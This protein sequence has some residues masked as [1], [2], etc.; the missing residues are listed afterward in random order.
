MTPENVRTAADARKIVEERKLDHIKVGVFDNDGVMRGKYMGRDKF[1]SALDK[2][3]GFCDVVLG[4]DSNDQLYD[5]V[6]YTGWHTAYPDAP[7]RVLPDTCRNVPFEGD[8]VMF[9]GEFAEKAEAVCP[10][11]T[12][13]RVLKKAD[14]LGYKVNAATEFEFFMFKETPESIRAKGFRDLTT[15]TPGFFGYSVLRSSVHSEFYHQ[16]MNMCTGLRIPLEGL[17]TETGPGVLEAAIQYC[18]ALEAADR[19]ALFKTYTKVLAQRNGMMATFMAKWSKDWPGQ[20]G[21]IHTSLIRKSDGKAAFHD[22]SKPHNMSDEMRWFVGGQQKLMPELLAMVACTVNSYSRLIPGFWAPTTATWGVE[23]RTCALRVIPGGA[24]SQRV[25]YRIAA[26]DINPYLALAVAIGS[27]LHGIEN[28]IEPDA[29]VEGN[30]YDKKFL[31]N[32]SLPRTLTEASEWLLKSR[33]GRALFGDDFVE[34]FAASREWEDREFRRAIT[35]WELA[36]YF[37]II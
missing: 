30:A 6:K 31:K 7:V 14:E 9:L 27:G 20:S 13:R 22:A 23:N 15:M 12:L 37:E 26:A 17:H 8:M 24:S 36:R 4:W 25:E 32:R 3:F 1:F 5:N 18:E 16:L 10:R 19:G 34:H 35:D 11:A 28:K 21:H 2:G 29:M 33:A